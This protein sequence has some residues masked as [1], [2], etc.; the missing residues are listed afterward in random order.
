MVLEKPTPSSYEAGLIVLGTLQQVW[1]LLRA[2]KSPSQQLMH[3]GP[4]QGMRA[5]LESGTPAASH[6]LLKLLKCASLAMV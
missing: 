5:S 4:C 1:Q 2:V 6:L 3:K